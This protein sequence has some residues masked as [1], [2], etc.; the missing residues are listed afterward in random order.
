VAQVIA[1]KQNIIATATPAN[2][3]AMEKWLWVMYLTGVGIMLCLLAWDIVRLIVLYRSGKKSKQ[4]IWTIIETR[5]EHTPFS[6]REVLFV[7]STAQYTP[8][9]WQII[10]QHEAQHTRLLHLADVLLLQISKIIFWFHPLSYIYAKRLLLVHEYQADHFAQQRPQAYGQFL[11][12]QA[13]LGAAPSISHSFNRS[14]IKK[15]IFMLTRTSSSIAKS[16]MLVLLP[17]AFACVLCFSK[18]SFSQNAKEKYPIVTGFGVSNANMERPIKALA[19]TYDKVFANPKL[20]CNEPNCEVTEFDFSYLPKGKDYQGPYHITGAALSQQVLGFF[21]TDSL[22]PKTRIFI[23]NITV[24]R[25]GKE[26]KTASLI[27]VCTP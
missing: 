2:G 20:I 11:I 9:E 25:N 27:M 16:K 4:G 5:K 1:A 15:R 7:N 21:K 22:N 18:N 12:E 10:L 26:E 6:F 24:R 13:L 8:A 3:I 23:E 14:P 17:L 19:T